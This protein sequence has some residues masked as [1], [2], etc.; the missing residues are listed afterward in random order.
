M[1]ASSF[2]QRIQFK[3]PFDIVLSPCCGNLSS[4]WLVDVLLCMTPCIPLFL[5]TRIRCAP[6]LVQ[7]STPWQPRAPSKP[8]ASTNV[9]D[10]G[11]HRACQCFA[12]SSPFSGR[13]F[14]HTSCRILDAP[15]SILSSVCPLHIGGHC[16]STDGHG[17][18][19]H[20]LAMRLDDVHASCEHT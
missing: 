19:E 8:H 11:Y 1:L 13:W 6:H 18:V 5:T 17:H 12:S 7:A 15:R 2:A 20:R 9:L 10:G 4:P 3:G 16:R 14:Y